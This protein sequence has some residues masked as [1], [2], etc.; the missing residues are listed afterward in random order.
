[1]APAHSAA[2][3]FG[4]KK[5]IPI[6]S[7]RKLLIESEITQMQESIDRLVREAGNWYEHSPI[8]TGYTH[9]NQ[10]MGAGSGFGNN[11]Q[12]LSIKDING[13]KQWGVQMLRIQNNPTISSIKWTDI[14][15]GLNGQIR[16]ENWIFNINSS[17]VFSH[18]YAWVNKQQAFNFF[19]SLSAQYRINNF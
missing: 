1:M 7:N 17:F 18:N 2:Y 14:V 3:L 11:V 13:W 16:K 12:M 6:K 9:Y 10:I 15:L 4:F 5:L 19:G 8:S